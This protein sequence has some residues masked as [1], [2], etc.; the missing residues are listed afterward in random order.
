M[1]TAGKLELLPVRRP[2]HSV[3]N[4]VLTL[5]TWSCSSTLRV[6]MKQSISSMKMMDGASLLAMLHTHNTQ[7][8]IE[9]QAGKTTN[10]QT[11][12]VHTARESQAKGHPYL[13]R[14]ASRSLGNS[15]HTRV[16]LG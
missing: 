1:S 10:E 14:T 5:T 7:H 9:M 6:L 16:F 3:M 11:R 8:T 13:A 4:S 2:S 12:A 15:H